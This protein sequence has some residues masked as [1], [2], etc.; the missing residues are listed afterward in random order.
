M[1]KYRHFAL[2]KP[3]TEFF[4]MSVFPFIGLIHSGNIDFTLFDVVEATIRVGSYYITRKIPL[5]FQV[6]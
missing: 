4:R 5:L 2:F 3:I 6:W 1:K